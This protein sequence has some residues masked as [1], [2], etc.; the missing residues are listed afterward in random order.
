MRVTGR[1]PLVST[2]LGSLFNVKCDSVKKFSTHKP[3]KNIHN[4]G[5][6]GTWFQV[7][8][9]PMLIKAEKGGYCVTAN[10]AITDNSNDKE[11]TFTC[12]FSYK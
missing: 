12:I 7:Y 4:A 9:S 5:L 8:A 10:I 3:V 1:I 6:V 2:F 11:T